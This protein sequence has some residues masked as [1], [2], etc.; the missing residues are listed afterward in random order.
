MH[1]KHLFIALAFGLILP[2]S[3]QVNNPAGRLKAH[4]HTLAADSLLGRG[5]GTPQGRTAARYIARQF[6]EAGI[7]PL[8]G[9]YFHPFD[10]RLG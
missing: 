2:L 8:N 10:H 7:E 6:R 9:T 1:K 4:V 5:F 3:S